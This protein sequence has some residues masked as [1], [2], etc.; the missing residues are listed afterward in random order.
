MDV[1]DC[2]NFIIISLLIKEIPKLSL[3]SVVYTDENDKEQVIVH[4]SDVSGV[5]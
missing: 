4:L 5:V 3:V 2:S 1:K